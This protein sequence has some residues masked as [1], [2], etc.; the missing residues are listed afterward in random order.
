MAGPGSY[1]IGQEEMDEVA[2]VLSGGYLM[3]YGDESDPRFKHKVWSFERAFEEN[4]EVKHALAVSS[5]TAALL[6][7]LAAL[8]I[9]PGDEVIVPGY[10]YMSSVSSIVYAGAVPVLAE[11]DETLTL[12]PEDVERRITPRTRGIMP[13]H[14]LGGPSHVDELKGLG[15]RYGLAIIEDACQS[16]G[17]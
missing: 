9:G 4:L 8:G 15:Q 13:V 12:D 2:A 10:C 11:I 16:L 7:A 3:R 5:G 6:T 14:M 1:L 17:G